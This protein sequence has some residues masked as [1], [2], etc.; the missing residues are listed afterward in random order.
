MFGF[1][2]NHTNNVHADNDWKYYG[3]LECHAV[4]KIFDPQRQGS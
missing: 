2:R 4:C 3:T 1:W